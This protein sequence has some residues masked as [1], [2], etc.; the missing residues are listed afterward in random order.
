MKFHI[1]AATVKFGPNRGSKNKKVKDFM[2]ELQ[3]YLE[4]GSSL[5]QPCTT[6]VLSW[7]QFLL[8]FVYR[9]MLTSYLVQL[10]VEDTKMKDVKFRTSRLAIVAV[11]NMQGFFL[12]LPK[13]SLLHW[14]GLKFSGKVTV[15]ERTIP[16][17]YQ[18]L[19]REAPS[20]TQHLK[21]L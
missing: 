17:D 8:R 21:K 2:T 12:T 3:A 20:W 9:K 15:V 10:R 16:C 13:T 18:S 19:V 14:G 11:T 6:S 4:Q 7:L 5:L 1:S